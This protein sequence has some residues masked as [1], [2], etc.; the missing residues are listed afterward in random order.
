MF[1]SLRVVSAFNLKLLVRLDI[2]LKNFKKEMPQLPS[3][4]LPDE[5][6]TNV[7][8]DCVAGV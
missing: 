5:E 3:V 8:L 4:F 7:R 2:R 1:F 6:T